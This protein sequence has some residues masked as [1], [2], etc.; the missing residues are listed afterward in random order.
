MSSKL[1]QFSGPEI[2]YA[3]PCHFCGTIIGYEGFRKG[4]QRKEGLIY[5]CK[6]KCKD[7]G[8]ELKR[9]EPPPDPRKA[10]LA[11]IEDKIKA[12]QTEAA[13]L[14]TVNILKQIWRV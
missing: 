7:R 11:N 1:E 5:F 2:K 8:K 3:I 12:G 14:D 4:Q 10:M 13:L 9:P 6:D